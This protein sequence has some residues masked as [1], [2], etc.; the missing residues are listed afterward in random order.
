MDIKKLRPILNGIKDI[1]AKNNLTHFEVMGILEVLR[2][3]QI[4]VYVQKIGEMPRGTKR[5]YD[6]IMKLLDDANKAK[7][8]GVD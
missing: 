1:F 4:L 8:G 6:A 7:N 3:D 2:A 5:E